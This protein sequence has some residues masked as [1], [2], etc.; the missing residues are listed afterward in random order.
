[1]KTIN[2]TEAIEKFD[3]NYE[4]M[5]ENKMTDTGIKTR[6]TEL[7]NGINA[8]NKFVGGSLKSGLIWVQIEENIIQYIVVYKGKLYSMH[9]E[10]DEL[11]QGKKTYSVFMGK[12]KIARLIVNS[13]NDFTIN[14]ANKI[15]Y[16]LRGGTK[17]A[18]QIKVAESL[19]QD[20]NDLTSY[21]FDFNTDNY[22]EYIAKMYKPVEDKMMKKYEGDTSWI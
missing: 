7:I 12:T 16:D 3:S 22:S 13:M 8:Y 21:T 19:I 2:Y 11:F 10:E 20:L 4:L 1:M 6:R 15:I 18:L 17:R 9:W 14:V 5:K